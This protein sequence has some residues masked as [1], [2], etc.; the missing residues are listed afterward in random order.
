MSQT[1]P[2]GAPRRALGA[3]GLAERVLH[4][5]GHPALDHGPPGLQALTHR[6]QPQGIQAQEGSQVRTGEGSVSHVEVLMTGE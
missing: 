4:A 1:A 5:D 2:D 3:A 6:Q